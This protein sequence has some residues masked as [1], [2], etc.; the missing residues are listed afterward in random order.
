MIKVLISI[1]ITVID[2]VVHE[3]L[4]VPTLNIIS[5]FFIFYFNSYKPPILI[6]FRLK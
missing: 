1:K 4:Q 6:K 2:V 3:S 5:L